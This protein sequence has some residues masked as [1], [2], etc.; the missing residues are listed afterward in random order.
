MS[1]GKVNGLTVV[2]VIILCILVIPVVIWF[3]EDSHI[4]RPNTV[5]VSTR[6]KEVFDPGEYGRSVIAVVRNDGA[7][8]EVTVQ[9]TLYTDGKSWQHSQR[10]Y[11]GKGDTREVRILFNE[12]K[13]WDGEWTYTVW[14]E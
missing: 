7:S 3:Y 8:G 5:V 10:V 14:V 12:P 4:F 2:G 6:S 9:A 1:K 13:L 11:I